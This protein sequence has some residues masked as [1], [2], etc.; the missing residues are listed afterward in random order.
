MTKQ[1]ARMTN[2]Q[3]AEVTQRQNPRREM[4]R[5]SAAHHPA[6]FGK[7]LSRGGEPEHRLKERFGIVKEFSLTKAGW[8][9]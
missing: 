1:Y 4:A 3:W 7:N 6:C 5:G 2:S 9:G 8:R